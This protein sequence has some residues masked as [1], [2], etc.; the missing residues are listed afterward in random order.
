MEFS[1]YS[2]AAL[3]FLRKLK[4][5]NR[6]SWFQPRKEIYERELKE[7]SLALIHAVNVEL[8]RFAPRYVTP[9]ARAMLRIYRDTRFSAN[10][11]PYK[12]HI[13]ALFPRTGATRLSGACFYFHFTAEELLVFCG[14]WNPP[15]DEL[16]LLRAHLAADHARLKKLAAGKTLREMFG[17]MQGEKLSRM[18]RGFPSEHPA[19]ELILG[20]QWYFECTLSPRTLLKHNAASIIAQHFRAAAPFVEFMNQPLLQARAKPKA[21]AENL[22]F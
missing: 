8:M 2:P 6:R 9:P 15:A 12:T 5:N 14:V 17:A 3:E 4:R 21:F 18:P 1:G 13:S 7:P 22:M 20:K 19:K 11:A 16:R 10:K